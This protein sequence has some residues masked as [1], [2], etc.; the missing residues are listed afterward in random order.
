MVGK[1]HITGSKIMC[2]DWSEIGWHWHL[3]RC[4]NHFS[5]YFYSLLCNKITVA[6]KTLH[7]KNVKYE[8]STAVGFKNQ[9]SINFPICS[10]YFMFLIPDKIIHFRWL[11]TDQ[12][13]KESLLEA[14]N[15]YAVHDG[16]TALLYVCTK[17]FLKISYLLRRSA[18]Q[19]S[20]VK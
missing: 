10:L 6:Y 18:L 17:C 14:E 3:I 20:F 1:T 4:I 19:D 16:N 13:L 9:W 2:F 7:L 15:H 8:C 11:H 5:M 12:K